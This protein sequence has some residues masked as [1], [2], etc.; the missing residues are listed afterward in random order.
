MIKKLTKPSVAYFSMEFGLHD[1]FKIYSG[2]L[3]IL[4][5]DVLKAAFDGNYPMVGVGI[6]WR[7]GYC[8]QF[9]DENGKPYDSYYEYKYEFLKDTGIVVSVKIR[10]RIVKCKVWKCTEYENVPL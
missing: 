7:Q 1:K 9:I 2:G 3:G 4:A 10:G 5:G 6:L 8:S